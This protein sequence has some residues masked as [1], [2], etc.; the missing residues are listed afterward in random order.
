[1]TFKEHLIAWMNQKTEELR[2]RAEAI[3]AKTAHE[4]AFTKKMLESFAQQTLEGCSMRRLVIDRLHETSWHGYLFDE[5]EGNPPSLY[6]MT[7][8]ELLDLYNKHC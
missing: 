6:A 2:A 3:R 5:H 7:D 1:M 8:A 4:T